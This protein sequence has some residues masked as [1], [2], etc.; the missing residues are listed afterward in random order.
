MDSDFGNTLIEEE[1][2]NG[3]NKGLVKATD[4]EDTKRLFV[5]VISPM[6]HFFKLS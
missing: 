6:V 4:D 1:E 3:M 2:K 5:K